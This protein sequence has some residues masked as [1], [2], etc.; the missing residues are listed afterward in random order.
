MIGIILGSIPT[1]AYYFYNKSWVVNDVICILNLG[2]L[3][4]LLKVTSFKDGIT[5]YI[6]FIIF[7]VILNLLIYNSD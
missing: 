6:P 4:K 7:L 5:I 3:F 1:I 2:A